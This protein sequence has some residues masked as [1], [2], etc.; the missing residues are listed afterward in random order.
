MAENKRLIKYL[1]ESRRESIEDALDYEL[2][3]FTHPILKMQT[4]YKQEIR[5]ELSEINA[6]LARRIIQFV[7]MPNGTVF[8]FRP[9]S[10]NIEDF[11][12]TRVKLRSPSWG[13][14]E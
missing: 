14:V 9:D 2:L 4:E 8:W 7:Y 11:T 12:G 10:S 3:T 5:C 6:E 13:V 1:L